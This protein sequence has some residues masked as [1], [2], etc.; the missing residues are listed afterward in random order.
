[1]KGQYSLHVFRHET[2]SHLWGDI[3]RYV[4]TPLRSTTQNDSGSVVVTYRR[5]LLTEDPALQEWFGNTFNFVLQLF[6]E[7]SAISNDKA[8]TLITLSPGRLK[9]FTKATS[10][11]CLHHLAKPCTWGC[12]YFGFL[13]Y[14]CSQ[15][16]SVGLLHEYVMYVM[17]HI[18]TLWTFVELPSQALVQHQ[19]S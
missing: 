12:S 18:D 3:T 8:S 5:V 11:C 9:N 14:Q 7:D 15:F 6:R 2:A 10:K 19:I 4:P 13:R 16:G 1:M 17:S